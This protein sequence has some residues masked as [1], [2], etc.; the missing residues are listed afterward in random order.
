MNEFERMK[1]KEEG[2]REGRFLNAY[3]NAP[4]HI[5]RCVLFALGLHDEMEVECEIEQECK[6]YDFN[7]FLKERKR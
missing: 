1:I 5:K 3:N 4:E 6:I 2:I 7:S